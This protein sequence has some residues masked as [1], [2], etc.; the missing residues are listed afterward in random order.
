MPIRSTERRVKPRG[1]MA[2]VAHAARPAI[3]ALAL[4][5]IALAL[6]GVIMSFRETRSPTA[7][8]EV[9]RTP[10]LFGGYDSDT[11]KDLFDGRC[12]CTGHGADDH[13]KQRVVCACTDKDDLWRKGPWQIITGCEWRDF[14]S[15]R[16]LLLSWLSWSG[17]AVGEW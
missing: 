16:C 11:L 5:T 10:S 14:V 15:L 3:A 8:L 2:S 6:A 13:S 17:A 12:R 9:V 1:I 7:M 4:T